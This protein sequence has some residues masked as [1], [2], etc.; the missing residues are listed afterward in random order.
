MPDES[1]GE[2]L[3]TPESSMTS[4]T[5]GDPL[6]PEMPVTESDLAS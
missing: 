1:I 2:A 4:E 6:A 5:A 3:S